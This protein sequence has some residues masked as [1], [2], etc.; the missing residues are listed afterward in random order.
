[1]E[2]NVK[3]GCPGEVTLIVDRATLILKMKEVMN[4]EVA[5]GSNIYFQQIKGGSI[6][7]TLLTI[8]LAVLLSI[9]LVGASFAQD[10]KSGKED[11]DKKFAASKTFTVEGTV[12]S[13]DVKCHC[14]VIKGPKGNVTVQDD[15]AEFNQEYNKAKGLKIGEKAKITYKTVDYINYATKVEQ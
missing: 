12:V 4:Q 14:I 8:S 1:M 7:K 9:V 10:V 3:N 5:V 6:M 11:F 13:H 15:Y 2:S